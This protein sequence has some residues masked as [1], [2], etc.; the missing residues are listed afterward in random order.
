MIDSFLILLWLLFGVVTVISLKDFILD[1]YSGVLIN[2]LKVFL[3]VLLFPAPIIMF[4]FCVVT[5]NGD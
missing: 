1:I 2:S 3:A 5:Y 4:I